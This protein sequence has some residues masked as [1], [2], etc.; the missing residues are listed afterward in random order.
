MAHP[1]FVP[2]AIGCPGS[3]WWPSGTIRSLQVSESTGLSCKVK[4]GQ[5]EIPF[6]SFHNTIAEVSLQTPF[7]T[8]VAVT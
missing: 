3:P 2:T 4:V 1:S 8:M 6:V 5:G 7:S